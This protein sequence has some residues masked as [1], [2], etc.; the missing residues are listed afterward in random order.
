MPPGQLNLRVWQRLTSTFPDQ[1]IISAIIGICE[2]GARIGHEGTRQP[3]TILP[4]L[5]FGMIDPAQVTSDIKNELSKNRLQLFLDTG[6][7]P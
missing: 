2:F 7:L 3:T 4:N 5:A 6:S 1:A